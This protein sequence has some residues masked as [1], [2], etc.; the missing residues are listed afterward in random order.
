MAKLKVDSATL[1]AKANG[2]LLAMLGLKRDDIKGKTTTAT[3]PDAQA[4]YAKDC[5]AKSGIS[6]TEG[7]GGAASDDGDDEGGG[8]DDASGSRAKKKTA[9]KKKKKAKKARSRG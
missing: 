5:L 3:V 4:A 9:K 8:D 6:F 1:Q 2:P 7:K